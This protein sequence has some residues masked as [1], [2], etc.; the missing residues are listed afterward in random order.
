MPYK[1][2]IKAVQE[3]IF[4]LERAKIGYEADVEIAQ[5]Q[6]AGAKENRAHYASVVSDIEN[7]NRDAG[8]IVKIVAFF[9]HRK[10]LKEARAYLALAEYT[11]RV[12]A[13]NIVA[14]KVKLVEISRDLAQANMDLQKLKQQQKEAER[15]G[16][17]RE[18][19]SARETPEETP[20][21]EHEAEETE[22]TPEE[23]EVEEEAEETPEEEHEAEE[24]EETPEEPDAEEEAEE[25]PRP[26]RFTEVVGAVASAAVL[27]GDVLRSAAGSV[28]AGAERA[29][30]AIHQKATEFGNNVKAKAQEVKAGAVKFA[31]DVR[32]S[33]VRTAGR[34]KEGAHKVGETI[35]AKAQEVKTGAVKFAGDVRESAVR[36]AGRVKEGAQKVGDAVREKAARLRESAVATATTMGASI[37]DGAQKAYAG[38]MTAVAATGKGIVAAAKKAQEG[39]KNAIPGVLWEKKGGQIDLSTPRNAETLT[40]VGMTIDGKPNRFAKSF[41]RLVSKQPEV[42]ASL[43]AG[44]VEHFVRTGAERVA[45]DGG[46][47]PGTYMQRVEAQ[48]RAAAR[49]DQE[50]KKEVRSIINKTLRPM[51]RD[52]QRTITAEKKQER[53]AQKTMTAESGGPALGI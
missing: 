53:L 47:K 9:L 20:E 24:T 22:E 13:R 4:N 43:P 6:Q 37:K 30:D 18:V 41:E 8:I 2:R 11:E 44:A 33:A 28:R 52:A 10:K 36:T 50:K 34:V 51:E 14:S 3:K 38:Y 1:N 45:P 7:K 21:E 46:T 40:K 16:A 31:G 12:E 15:T 39:V 25:T 27:T 19:E 48:A 32:E 17:A 35:T 26:G 42:I 29:A 23:P 5:I 49:E